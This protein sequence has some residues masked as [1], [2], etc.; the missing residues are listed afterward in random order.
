MISNIHITLEHNLISASLEGNIDLTESYPL[1]LSLDTRLKKALLDSALENEQL[2]LKASG[3]LDDMSI[4][5]DAAGEITA[6]LE[7]N[8]DALSPNMPFSVSLNWNKLSWPIGTPPKPFISENGQLFLNGSLSEYKLALNAIIHVP[9]YPVATVNLSATGNTEQLNIHTL[10]LQE[11]EN[12]TNQKAALIISG[13][14]G[15]QERLHWK[16]HTSL[17]NLNPAL[18]IP[19]YPGQLNGEADSQFSLQKDNL[20]QLAIPSLSI[21][22]SLRDSSLR[23]YPVNLTAAFSASHLSNDAALFPFSAEIKTLNLD[24]GQNHLTARGKAVRSM[25][26]TC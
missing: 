4:A 19:D 23:T 8:I 21:Q 17:I 12:K 20:W 15:W 22:G 26:I 10:N 24:V 25:V 5:L 14:L 1:E 6:S 11:Q 16:G 2:N 9:E 13:Q 3:S 18:L 7:G